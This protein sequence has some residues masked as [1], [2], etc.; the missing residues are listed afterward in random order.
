MGQHGFSCLPVVLQFS[1]VGLWLWTS[2][3]HG[4]CFSGA[5]ISYAQLLTGLALLAFG[6]QLNVGIFNAIGTDGVYYGFKL[7]V[8]VGA[9]RMHAAVRTSPCL[10]SC[11]IVDLLHMCKP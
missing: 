6:Q 10:S 4:L 2:R 9:S 8:K 11:I 5:D 7:G 1:A 3:K